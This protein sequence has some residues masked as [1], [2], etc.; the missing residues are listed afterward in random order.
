MK[1]L[2]STFTKHLG[3]RAPVIIRDL[4]V[5]KTQDAKYQGQYKP[6]MFRPDIVRNLL[7]S[8]NVHYLSLDSLKAIASARRLANMLHARV[9]IVHFEGRNIL[10]NQSQKDYFDRNY[11]VQIHTVTAA[12]EDAVQKKKEGK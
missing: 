8:D 11:T 5:K 12:W 2:A 3:P 1:H 6:I 7:P 10:C 4:T 9:Y